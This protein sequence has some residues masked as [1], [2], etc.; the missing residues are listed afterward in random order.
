MHANRARNASR[1]MNASHE[2]RATRVEHRGRLGPTIATSTRALRRWRH[3]SERRLASQ[4]GP[5]NHW[6][7]RLSVQAES[8]V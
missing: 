5:M 8:Q 1:E 4:P 3:I 2:K 7:V 6:A